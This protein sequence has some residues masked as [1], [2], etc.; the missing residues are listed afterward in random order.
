MIV[1][2]SLNF[3]LLAVVSVYWEVIHMDYGAIIS[4]QYS[5]KIFLPAYSIYQQHAASKDENS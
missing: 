3:T 4:K 2:S 1:K 5:S